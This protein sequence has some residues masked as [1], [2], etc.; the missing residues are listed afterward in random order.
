MAWLAPP[1]NS[2]STRDGI[3]SIFIPPVSD[4]VFWAGFNST[5]WPA[6]ELLF[7][8]NWVFL[9][10][11][12]IS[13]SLNFPPSTYGA[14]CTAWISFQSKKQI[15]FVKLK[16]QLCLNTH[17][18]ETENGTSLG[19]PKDHMQV[20]PSQLELKIPFFSLLCIPYWA[21]EIFSSITFHK[22]LCNIWGKKEGVCRGG[23]AEEQGQRL[24]RITA[25]AHSAPSRFSSTRGLPKA[26]AHVAEPTSPAPLPRDCPDATWE[27]IRHH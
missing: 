19:T 2:L 1:G 27:S 13:H 9:I 11:L 23:D 4:E 3:P 24:L 5:S 22:N 6:L 14:I 12:W 10:F 15:I 18:V 8:F 17:L 16:N 20:L 7:S 26:P 25:P 21:T